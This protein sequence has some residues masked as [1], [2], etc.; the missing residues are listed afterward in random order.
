MTTQ[1]EGKI[2]SAVEDAK[3]FPNPTIE[4]NFDEDIDKRYFG[5]IKAIENKNMERNSA[6]VIYKLS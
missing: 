3:Q 4:Y 5:D 1:N 6:K 2:E